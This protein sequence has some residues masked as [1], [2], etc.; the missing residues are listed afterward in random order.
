M[1]EFI[2]GENTFRAKP[3]DADV[4]IGLMLKLAPVFTA[5]ASAAPDIMAALAERG[6][7]EG[8]APGVGTDALGRLGSAVMP[9]SREIAALD[10]T[11][12]AKSV[13]DASLDATE[14]LADGKW[15]KVRAPG[16]VISN[17][18]NAGYAAKLQ[19]TFAVLKA[20]FG[21]MVAGFGVDVD[22]IFGTVSGV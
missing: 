16:G 1:T 14:Q 17:R 5:L 4:H 15:F 7:S 21:P 11:G 9:V 2:I 6:G 19:I 3:F 20:N 10:R 22:A 8:G 13:I 18:D 12:D